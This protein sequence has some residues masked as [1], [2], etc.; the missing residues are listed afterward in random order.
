VV[1]EETQAGQKVTSGQRGES[2]VLYLAAAQYA[3]TIEQQ[4]FSAVQQTGIVLGPVS[5]CWWTPNFRSA[6]LVPP[7]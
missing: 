1:N 7:A 2:V 6:A 4:G 3:V 5:R